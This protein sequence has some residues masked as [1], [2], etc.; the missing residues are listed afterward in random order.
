PDQE[1]LK[2]VLER[3]GLENVEF[4]NLGAG[5]VAVHRGYKI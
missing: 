5:V 1:S 2:A 4:F 3:A